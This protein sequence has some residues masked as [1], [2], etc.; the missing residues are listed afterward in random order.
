MTDHDDLVNRTLTSLG[1][2]AAAGTAERR[3]ARFKSAIARLK[4]DATEMARIDAIA[5]DAGIED[6][7][8]EP[9]A[10][11]GIAPGSRWLRL[12]SRNPQGEGL[13]DEPDAATSIVPGP[14][15]LSPAIQDPRGGAAGKSL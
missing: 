12:A 9:D 3:R 6:L 11:T 4:T 13:T 2:E 1:E 10:A 7:T 14:G 5:A 8:D 15:W